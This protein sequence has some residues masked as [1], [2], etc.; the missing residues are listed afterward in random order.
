[1]PVLVLDGLCVSDSA[2]HR[3]RTLRV[4][5]WLGR[6]FEGAAK[7]QV[8]SGDRAGQWSWGGEG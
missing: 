4:E 1:M 8:R 7:D 6:R 5:E 2:G 3:V